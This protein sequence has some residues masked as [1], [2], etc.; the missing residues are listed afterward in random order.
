MV[1]GHALRSGFR[2]EDFREHKGFGKR[3]IFNLFF[4]KK[5]NMRGMWLTGK[6]LLCIQSS[7]LVGRIWVGSIQSTDDN[8]LIGIASLSQFEIGRFMIDP[9]PLR[10][11]PN[12][13]NPA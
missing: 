1:R 13:I 9:V 5:E 7:I 10:D 12:V 8:I 3:A 2:P 4:D 11:H 6:L